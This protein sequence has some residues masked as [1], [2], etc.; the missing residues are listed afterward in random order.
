MTKPSVSA[1]HQSGPVLEEREECP[2]LLDGYDYARLCEFARLPASIDEIV[3]DRFDAHTEAVLDLLWP[4][5]LQGPLE[6]L[7]APRNG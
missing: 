2:L 6:R 3:V 4:S 5:S 1:A 7:G